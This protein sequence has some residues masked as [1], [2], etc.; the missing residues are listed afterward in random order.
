L[1]PPA[2]YGRATPPSNPSNLSPP[3]ACDNPTLKWNYTGLEYQRGSFY[4]ALYTHTVPPNYKGRDCLLNF[5]FDQGH[6]A[7]RSYH[8]GGVNL[9]MA[10]GSVRF[11]HETI[12]LPVWKALGTRS[13]GEPVD[14]QSY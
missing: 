4:T 10:D 7:S 13:G 11:I 5:T 14:T 1:L 9:A 2:T 6:L 8:A 3:A 12:R